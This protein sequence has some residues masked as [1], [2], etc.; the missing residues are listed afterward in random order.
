MNR[1]LAR[2]VV[3]AIA[4]PCAE[5][6]FAL[7]RFS[8]R[9]WRRSYHWLITSGLA[10]HLLAVLRTFQAE[11]CLPPRICERM[12]GL[13]LASMARTDELRRDYLELNRRFE[14]LGTVYVNWKG[15]AL[16]PEFC[17]DVRFRPQMD[18]DFIVQ[19]EGADLFDT[20]LR[21][22]GYRQ[23]RNTSI[24]ATYENLP[25]RPYSL[26]GVY[27]LKPQRKVELHFASDHGSLTTNAMD[28]HAALAR[29]CVVMSGGQ[30]I[31]V[32]APADAFLGHAAHAGRHALEGWVRLG[33][34]HEIDYF[35]RRHAS[36]SVLWGEVLRLAL[37][38]NAPVISAAVGILLAKQL[39]HRKLAVSLTWAEEALPDSA[40]RWIE[41]HG[42]R[43]ALADFPG[44]KL[45]LLLQREL[46]DG[47]D[48]PE[49]ERAALFRR[50]AIPRVVHVPPKATLRQRAHISHL[51]FRFASRR[52]F[53]HVVETARYYVLKWRWSRHPSARLGARQPC[54]AQFK[55]H[56]NSLDG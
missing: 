8:A 40:S 31:P 13:D 34:L 7:R 27:Q 15:F 11:H 51:Q 22:A 2:T 54:N 44:T 29:R 41:A 23:T 35:V 14:G 28:L 12:N 20:E 49:I 39:W 36:D 19:P 26:E 16:E 17:E 32:L 42:D 33:W 24:E 10:L 53:F 21:A 6:A 55:A 50:R 56:S 48:W 5:H 25:H 37:L 4:C 45:N 46:S 18:F 30:S 43:L 38:P 47:A 9:D 1:T 52:V 3:D